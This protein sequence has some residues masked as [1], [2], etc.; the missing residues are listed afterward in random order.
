MTVNTG[1]LSELTTDFTSNVSIRGRV[2][3]HSAI[4]SPLLASFGTVRVGSGSAILPSLAFNSEASLGLYRST[5]SQIA[6]SYG[7]FI[8]GDGAAITPSVAFASDVSRGIYRSAASTIAFTSGVTLNL[9]TGAVK[10]S[11]DTRANATGMGIGELAIVFLNSGISLVYSSG[12][13]SYVLG[14]SS[15]SAAQA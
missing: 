11:W 5:T 7:Q 9:R 12:A 13:S 3:W 1:Y 4:S 10:V 6:V 8:L 2:A 15:Q 14:Q